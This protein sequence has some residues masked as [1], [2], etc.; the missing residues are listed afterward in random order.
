[1]KKLVQAL[2]NELIFEYYKRT[3][4]LKIFWEIKIKAF[5]HNEPLSCIFF[6]CTRIIILSTPRGSKF[7]EKGRGDAI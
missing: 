6:S 1:M 3:P 5:Q 4:K 7:D 2:K